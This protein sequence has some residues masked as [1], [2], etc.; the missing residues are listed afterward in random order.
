[1]AFKPTAVP[2]APIAT[3]G[4]WMSWMAPG[5]PA[6]AATPVAMAFDPVVVSAHIE[7]AAAA[8]RTITVAAKVMPAAG[9]AVLVLR[10]RVVAVTGPWMMAHQINVQAIVEPA[11]GLAALPI[12]VAAD[13]AVFLPNLMAIV[14][15]DMAPIAPIGT[16]ATVAVSA[17]RGT[18]VIAKIGCGVSNA[19]PT[20][21]SRLIR[22]AIPSL[23]VWWYLTNEYIVPY[24][25]MADS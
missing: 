1:M 22:C 24:M 21:L 10:A 16:I 7:K 13:V 6:A 5:A 3:T 23:I 4:G 25:G 17:V 9:P 2:A 14:M 11:M 15:P 20:L 18:V 12:K 19:H 8:M